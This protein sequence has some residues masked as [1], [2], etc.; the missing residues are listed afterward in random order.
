MSR[1][2]V[3][4]QENQFQYGRIQDATSSSYHFKC[5]HIRNA[6][7]SNKR[8]ASEQ[9]TRHAYHLYYNMRVFLDGTLSDGGKF[10]VRASRSELRFPRDL[11]FKDET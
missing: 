7:N 2:Q 5:K 11:N 8:W 4:I 10:I 1:H 3:K 9:S 6:Y